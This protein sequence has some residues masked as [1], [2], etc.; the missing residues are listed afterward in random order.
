DMASR[1][2]RI[3]RAQAALLGVAKPEDA[4]GR[5]D[6]D[7]Q[8][9]QL[10]AASFLEERQ[11]LE[12]GVTVID[13]PEY[14]PTAD[15]QPRWLSSNKVAMRDRQG[16]IVGLVGIS[17]NIT[18]RMRADEA[19]RQANAQLTERVRQMSVLN[20]MQE[21]L[22]ACLTVSEVFQ[23]T[24]RM[25]S[26]LFPTECGALYV[27]N[28]SRNWIETAATWGS[29]AL[30]SQVLGLEDCWAL[31]LGRAHVVGLERASALPCRHLAGAEPALSVC[32][33]LLAQSETLG[34]W[35]LRAGNEAAARRFD[36][37]MLQLAR[38][39]AD[40]VALAIVNLNL[41]EKLRQQS[42]RD[43][44]TDLFNRRYM[45]ESLDL[46]LQR[47]ARNQR[48]VGIIMLDV[49]HF[50]NINDLHGHGAGD[51]VLRQLGRFLKDNTRGGDIA[52]RYGGEE[53]TLILPD[54]TLEQTQRRA[55][56][57]RLNF[58]AIDLHHGDRSL[59]SVTLSFGV[60]AYPQHGQTGDQVLRA[61]DGALYRSKH[62]GRDQVQA[63]S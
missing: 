31:R 28:N 17:H 7:F 5:T 20:E 29:P 59:G 39:V 6:A 22:Q 51:A 58:K 55:E 45:E 53:F 26:Q 34:V 52:C 2:T 19:L 25:M 41:R 32:I 4:L 8:A 14:N 46:E 43:P 3:N 49:D 12:T 30:E 18:E 15:G 47:A 42:I 35:H 37:V 44:L 40:S 23:I 48:P 21:Q 36:D 61:A 27:T 11:I 57:H 38:V 10:A 50:K 16:R 63:A 62:E 54:A 9:P 33:P 1:F 24:S 13:R 56:M 60:A